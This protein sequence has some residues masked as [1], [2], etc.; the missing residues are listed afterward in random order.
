[1][2]S[3]VKNFL[4]GPFAFDEQP[5]ELRYRDHFLCT[6]IDRLKPI[7]CFFWMPIISVMRT[8]WV[9]H[10]ILYP[11]EKPWV[12]IVAG[13]IRIFILI[14]FI[15]IFC[16]VDKMKTKQKLR[17]GKMLVWVARIL[18]F[19]V[20]MEQTSL[21]QGDPHMMA[22]LACCLCLCGLG[23]PSFTNYILQ[24]L[25]LP[26]IRPL[27]LQY[28]ANAHGADIGAREVLFQHLL[29]FG[30]GGSI[31]WTIH[32]DTRRR[33]LSSAS[34]PV[35]R[36][37]RPRP[38]SGASAARDSSLSASNWTR[39]RACR[40]GKVVAETMM[41]T[42]ARGHEWDLLDDGYF[43]ETDLADQRSEALQAGAALFVP[44]FMLLRHLQPLVAS[45][46]ASP[47]HSFSINQCMGTTAFAEAYDY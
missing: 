32:A 17:I 10:W 36:I 4:S 16:T 11:H 46:V 28:S 43:S 39:S 3:K 7:L 26:F 27:L 40:R 29:I 14:T 44:L 31:T 42:V 13:I 37:R 25:P 45:C 34:D 20:F 30:L 5:M 6:S 21:D 15:F 1:M 47:C 33:W 12:E 9:V 24:S 38:H 23:I 41:E 22:A 35:Q 18:A 19:L 2:H 8:C